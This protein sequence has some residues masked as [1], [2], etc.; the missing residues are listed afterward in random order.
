MSEA[1]SRPH[2]ALAHS[3]ETAFAAA[4][5]PAD[6]ALVEHYRPNLHCAECEG[7]FFAFRGKAWRDLTL[8]HLQSFK[9]ALPLFAP[10]GFRYVLP[11]Y[12][13]ACLRDARAMDTALP[14]LLGLLTPPKRAQSP[15]REKFRQHFAPLTQSQRAAVAAYLGFACEQVRADPP[16]GRDLERSERALA[17][18]LEFAASD[19]RV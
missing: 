10:E 9:D 13:L 5:R 12:M 15:A 18:W 17:F 1:S 16:I 6:D 8:E 11:A 7:L 4:A 14:S 19:E 3:I 2:T